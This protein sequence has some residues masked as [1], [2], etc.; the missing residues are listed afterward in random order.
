M[1]SKLDLER[2]GTVLVVLLTVVTV[3][4]VVVVNGL[5]LAAI[6]MQFELSILR[7]EPPSTVHTAVGQQLAGWLT[8]DVPPGDIKSLEARAGLVDHRAD[9]L[10]EATAVVALGG[11]L[12]ALVSL[13]P[14]GEL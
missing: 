11:M 3:V 5:K 1:R 7:N 13:R 14:A 8:A 6:E 4:S 2:V 9:R 12:V 10:L